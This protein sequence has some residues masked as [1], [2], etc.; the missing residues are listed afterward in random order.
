M[1]D[2]CA[3]YA[4]LS[5]DFAATVAA[6][7]A[8]RWASTSPCEGWDARDVVRHVVDTQDMFLG[9]V[10]REPG[11]VPSVDEDPRAAWDA[12]RAAVQAD[13]D[14]PDRANTEFDGF[15][16]RTTFAEA[17]DRFLNFDLVVHRWDLARATGQD[18]RLDPDDVRW[19]H[20]AT[21]AFGPH[22]RA[23][24][25]CGPELTPPEG[26]DAQTRFLAFVGRRAW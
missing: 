19:A 5:E 14:D 10:G 22:M 16:G 15:F 20:G 18:E 21:A 4:R 25:V 13:L 24:G 6:V 9:L 17:V 26:A 7:P 8:D 23:E 2:V 3:R 11:R 12:A 1:S